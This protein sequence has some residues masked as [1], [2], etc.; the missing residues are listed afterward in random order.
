MFEVALIL[1]GVVI[2]SAAMAVGIGGGILWTPL[3]ILGYGLTPA[4]AI[5]TSLFIQVAGLGSGTVAYIKAGLVNIK[6]SS[7]FFLIA[8]PGVIIGSF[9]SIKLSQGTV[10]M[11]LGL[12]AMTLAV[13]FVAGN[14][15]SEQATRTTIDAKQIKGIAAIPAFF[16]FIMGFLSLGISEWLIPA[17]RNK[18]CMDMQQAIATS[19]AMM[20]LLPV[21]AS[22][23]HLSLSDKLHSE[24]ILFG[25]IGTLIGAQIGVHISQRI[26]EQLLKQS[27]IYLMT[28]I[29]IHLI[30]Q[31]I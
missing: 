27:F 23:I 9:I 28:L 15:D 8:L 20:F 6:L 2:S 24:I 10:Q 17:L 31:A 22:S 21:V 1:F 3:L 4:E 12:M 14:Q 5:G 30:F 26:N 25:A 29:G 13:L 11:A 19:I 16:G 7:I 18:L